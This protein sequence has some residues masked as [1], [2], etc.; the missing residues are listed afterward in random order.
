MCIMSKNENRFIDIIY[1]LGKSLVKVHK[2][3][4]MSLSKTLY[5]VLITGST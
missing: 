4:G 3:M 5:P 1:V 2:Y